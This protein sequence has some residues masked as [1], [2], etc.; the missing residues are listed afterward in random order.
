MHRNKSHHKKGRPPPAAQAPSPLAAAH[1]RA[2]I[3]AA[4]LEAL[5]RIT[6]ARPEAMTT[7]VDTSL[8]TKRKAL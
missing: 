4:R 3:T 5:D 1:R 8:E 7:A 2:A 6:A